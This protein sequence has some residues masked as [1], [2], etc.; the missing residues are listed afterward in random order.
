MPS[1]IREYRKS[2]SVLQAFIAVGDIIISLI[3]TNRADK[4]GR[5]NTLIFSAILKIFAGI[6]YALSE[7]YL[8]LLISGALGVLTISGG[9][10]S[11]SASRTGSHS[12]DHRGQHAWPKQRSNKMWLWYMG[13]TTWLA[14]FHKQQATYLL[15]CTWNICQSCKGVHLMITMFISYSCTR[16]SGFWKLS[17]IWIRCKVPPNRWRVELVLSCHGVLK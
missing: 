11:F 7:N 2:R 3:L 5:R 15:G 17:A 16:F 12:A 1:L 13:T 10:R 9:N 14:T 4:I 8:I 6:S